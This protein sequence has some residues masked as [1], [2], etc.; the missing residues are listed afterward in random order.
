MKFKT[1]DF[2]WGTMKLSTGKYALIRKS[3]FTVNGVAGYDIMET[4]SNR[5]YY[6]SLAAQYAAE[7]LQKGDKSY[8]ECICEA[9]YRA[10]KGM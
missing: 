6:P 9:T 8:D 2:E 1:S 7:L 5:G 4:W 10:K 3:D